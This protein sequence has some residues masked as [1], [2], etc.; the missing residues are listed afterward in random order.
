MYTMKEACIQAGIAYETLRFY[1]KE[2]LVPNV[3][4]DQSNYRS[5]DERNISW[6]KSLQCLRQCG[7]G[8]DDMKRYMALCLQG[9]A[10]IPE[11][12]QMLARQKAQLLLRASE[13]QESID[14]IDGKQAFYDGVLAGEVAYTSNLIDVEAR[15][16]A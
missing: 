8:I 2:G 1:C 10:S 5:F 15:A 12:R 13:I 7:M 6:I 3:A 14:F 11:R 9:V 4:R 16:R